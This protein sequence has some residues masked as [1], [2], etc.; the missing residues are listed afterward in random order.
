MAHEL[1]HAA[2]AKYD[3]DFRAV[4]EFRSDVC[5]SGYM[6]GIVEEKL[7]ESSDPTAEVTTLCAPEQTQSCIHGIGHGAMFVTGLD[8]AKA[9]NL[10]ARFSSSGAATACSE[11]IYMQL[12]E[13]DESDPSAMAKLP[14]D[15]LAEEP[16]YPCPGR[17]AEFRS[18]CYYYAPAYFLQRNNYASDQTA[19][20]RGLAWCRNAPAEDSGMYTCTKGLGSRLMKY[21]IDREVWSAEQCEAAAADQ[22]RPCI[23]GMVSY[24]SVHHHS[25]NAV[26]KLCTKLSGRAETHC[27]E[28]AGYSTSAD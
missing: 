9:E 11:G 18:A 10:C 16:L 15:R 8:I 23:E 7:R 20:A 26:Q 28:A 5:G 19:Y 2:L 3:G 27:N 25:R 13:P 14:A 21:N 12:F 4:S 17:P 6:H 1:G 24:Y 22:R